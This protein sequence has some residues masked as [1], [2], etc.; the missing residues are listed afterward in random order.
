MNGKLL[1]ILARQGNLPTNHYVAIFGVHIR[2]RELQNSPYPL[3]DNFFCH[4][5]DAKW[6]KFY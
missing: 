2:N 4:D 5:R 1:V 3:L 6:I